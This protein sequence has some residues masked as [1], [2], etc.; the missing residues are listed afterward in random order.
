MPPQEDQPRAPAPL[1]EDVVHVDSGAG[2]LRQTL[3]CRKARRINSPMHPKLTS[4]QDSKPTDRPRPAVSNSHQALHSDRPRAPSESRRS[5]DTSTSPWRVAY[6]VLVWLIKAIWCTGRWAISNLFFTALSWVRLVTVLI[7]VLCVVYL[8]TIA[9][10]FSIFGPDHQDNNRGSPVVFYPPRHGGVLEG[11]SSQS[12]VL[13]RA[14]STLILADADDLPSGIPLKTAA[15][16]VHTTQRH[17]SKTIR[18]YDTCYRDWQNDALRLSY[19]LFTLNT[20]LAYCKKL[21]GEH[22][23]GG[24]KEYFFGFAFARE[25]PRRSKCIADLAETTLQC[26]DAH[27]R[28]LAQSSQCFKWVQ[29]DLEAPKKQLESQIAGLNYK[30]REIGTISE[31]KNVM[32]RVFNAVQSLDITGKLLGV[33]Q[34]GLSAEIALIAGS[35]SDFDNAQTMVIKRSDKQ[36]SAIKAGRLDD[37]ERDGMERYLSLFLESELA[38]CRAREL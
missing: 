8:L 16:I 11:L 38:I 2:T 23:D 19:Q 24:W 27:I 5:A 17:F 9:L 29:D 20:T 34:R 3:R 21:G 7:F 31:H 1:G 14:Y 25:P 6:T 15:T 4:P 36:K 13:R 35:I 32:Q 18:E 37:V 30:L 33:A 28:E 12:Y 26:I 22:V 10:P